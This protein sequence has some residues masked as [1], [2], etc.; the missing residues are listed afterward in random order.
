MPGCHRRDY[1][2]KRS[3]LKVNHTVMQIVS[4]KIRYAALRDSG[5]NAINFLAY[6]L[7]P[8]LV[9]PIKQIIL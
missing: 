6:R 1:A 2:Q 8:A 3:L 4:I 7:I 5:I 9:P